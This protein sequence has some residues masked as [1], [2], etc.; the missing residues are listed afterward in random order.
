MEK[1]CKHSICRS[2]KKLVRASFFVVIITLT[3]KAF[4]QFTYPDHPT[5]VEYFAFDSNLNENIY[6]TEHY[7]T[8]N[9]DNKVLTIKEYHGNEIQVNLWQEEYYRYLDGHL[10]STQID[11]YSGEENVKRVVETEYI[12][13]GTCLVNKV[14]FDE[15]FSLSSQTISYYDSVLCQ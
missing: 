4:S 12:Y 10:I 11:H 3:N 7:Y 9:E 6:K 2:T 14:V 8:Y 13:F 15:G 5:K 1:S